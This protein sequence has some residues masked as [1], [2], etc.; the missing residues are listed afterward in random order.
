MGHSKVI[1]GRTIVG[2]AREGDH[3]FCCNCETE[4]IVPYGEYVCPRCKEPTLAWADIDG[5]KEFCPGN[6]LYS[7][8]LILVMDESTE[9]KLEWVRN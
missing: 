6:P 8:A 3:V 9:R 1:K 4:M 7:T 2:Y 5:Y